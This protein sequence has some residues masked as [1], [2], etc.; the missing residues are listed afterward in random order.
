MK[1]LIL[2]AILILVVLGA[3]ILIHNSMNKDT[4]QPQTDNQPTPQDNIPS[5]S[6][7]NNFGDIVSDF[8]ENSG[9]GFPKDIFG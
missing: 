9:S 5:D 4:I 1:K 2:I 8:P 7:S 6:D 3:S